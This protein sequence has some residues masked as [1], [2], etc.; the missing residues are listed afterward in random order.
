MNVRMYNT[1]IQDLIKERQRKRE[2]VIVKKYAKKDIV[3]PAVSLCNNFFL[4]NHYEFMQKRSSGIICG[5]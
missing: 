1:F 5:K 3:K 4:N 2:R